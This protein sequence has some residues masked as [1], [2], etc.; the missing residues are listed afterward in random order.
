MA[1]AGLF[2]DTIDNLKPHQALFIM[3]WKM[4]IE[5]MYAREGQADYFAKSGSPYHGIACIRLY[6]EQELQ[7]Q[8]SSV[9]GKQVFQSKYKVEFIDHCI[10]NVKENGETIC[11]ILE[12]TF[13]LYKEENNH[14]NDII[15]FSDGGPC[16][17]PQVLYSF[18]STLGELTGLR[19]IAHYISE[20]CICLYIKFKQ[21]TMKNLLHLAHYNHSILCVPNL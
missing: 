16:Y 17:V 4:K 21:I 12:T 14:V 8:P 15:L 6:T 18:L 13:T 1:E 11:C 19:V 9:R 10:D 20:V 7:N 5:E 2:Q 3:D